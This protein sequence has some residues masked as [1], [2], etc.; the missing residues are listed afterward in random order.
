MHPSLDGQVW[1]AYEGGDVARGQLVGTR[2]GDRL[3]FRYVP[4]RSDGTTA[5]GH[6]VSRVTALPD[7]RL[8]LEEGWQWE[9]QPGSG[10]SAVEQVPG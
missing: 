1:A 10:T 9:S 5:S 6:C 4:L 8:R 3:D 7:G 2:T